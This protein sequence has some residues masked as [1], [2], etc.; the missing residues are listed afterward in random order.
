MIEDLYKDYTLEQMKTLYIANE[1]LKD[2]I[3]GKVLR[4]QVDDDNVG[5][6]ICNESYEV[7]HNNNFKWTY[8]REYLNLRVPSNWYSDVYLK[9]VGTVIYE[10]K[11]SLVLK[12][13][14]ISTNRVKHDLQ[15]PDMRLFTVWMPVYKSK[16]ELTPKPWNPK[17][18]QKSW[19]IEC[20]R[21]FMAAIPVTNS[22]LNFAGLT[23]NRAASSLKRHMM[24]RMKRKMNL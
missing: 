16:T 18:E 24:K 3:K 7:T 9:G 10:G 5:A 21:R 17:W 4:I 14:E 20:E 2:Q 12:A 8:T 23:E 13:R 15:I 22:V 11:V 6:E 19:Y 1:V